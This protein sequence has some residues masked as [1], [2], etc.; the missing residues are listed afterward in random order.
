[1][2]RASDLDVDH[3]VSLAWAHAH[4]AHSWR[5]SKREQFANDPENLLVVDDGLNQAKGKKWPVEW[6]PPNQSHHCD[7]LSHWKKVI[8]K[9]RLS[10][11]VE[12]EKD[13]QKLE[14]KNCNPSKYN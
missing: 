9:Y 6:L 12:E 14:R 1:M 13:L 11:S 5:S 8:S 2:A 7:Y 10:I 4:G 3:I